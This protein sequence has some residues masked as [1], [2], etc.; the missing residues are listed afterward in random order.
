[1]S[2]TAIISIILILV[3][4]IAVCAGYHEGYKEG[5]HA[6]YM[7]GLEALSAELLRRLTR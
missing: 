6:G 3:A 1:M 5:N 2:K 4:S 7:E